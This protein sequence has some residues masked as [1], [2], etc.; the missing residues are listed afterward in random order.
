MGKKILNP[1][2][3]KEELLRDLSKAFGNNM[4]SVIVFGSAATP[5]Y[6]P[7]K[8]DINILLVVRHDS[9][10][11][12][13]PLNG[14]E[15]KWASRKVVFSFFFTPSYIQTSLDAYPMEFMEI[16]RDHLLL[17]GIDFFSELEISPRLLRLQCERELKGKLLHLK[18]EHI[19]WSHKPKVLRSLLGVSF[20]QFLI[21][22]RNILSAA[23]RPE[24]PHSA[25]ELCAETEKAL[26]VDAAALK[27]IAEGQEVIF[28]EYIAAIEGITMAL[29]RMV[30]KE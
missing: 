3:L 9:V 15:K 8:S 13:A 25:A 10:Q 1:L 4:L 26:G 28:Q 5:R 20:S 18:R 11:A 12:M 23:G 22:F 7:G 19:R 14:L 16:R 30:V 27:R 21:I 17:H 6:V 2:D 24:V 29:D